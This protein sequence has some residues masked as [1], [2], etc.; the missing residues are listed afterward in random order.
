MLIGIN[1]SLIG[2]NI[3]LIGISISLVGKSTYGKNCVVF[4]NPVK[5]F[6]L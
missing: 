6:Q 1:I 3:S 4:K 5:V 2:I